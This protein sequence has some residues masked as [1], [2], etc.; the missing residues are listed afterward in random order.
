[1][2]SRG[3]TDSDPV[4]EYRPVWVRDYNVLRRETYRRN[5]GG[6]NGSIWRERNGWHYSL[7]G[8]DRR[9]LAAS[10]GLTGSLNFPVKTLEN[11]IHVCEQIVLAHRAG[12][13]VY[14]K[15]ER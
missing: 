10:K 6:F 4:A 14:G 1:M 15:G 9:L 2:T 5:H 12:A 13:G 11:A 8:P 3:V 7:H